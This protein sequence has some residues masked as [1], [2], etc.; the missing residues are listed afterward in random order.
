MKFPLLLPIIFLLLILSSL[1]SQ[2]KWRQLTDADGLSGNKISCIYQ[3]K[4]NDI[5][6]GTDKGINRYN[7]IFQGSPLDGSVNSILELPTGQVIA[8]EVITPQWSWMGDPWVSIKLYDGL[9]WDRPDFFRSL[10]PQNDIFKSRIPEFAV[11]SGGKLWMASRDGLISFDG[12]KWQFEDSDVRDLLWLV[13]TPDG[14]LWSQSWDSIVSFDGQKWTL[15]FGA[16]NSLLDNAIVNTALATLNGMI[17]LGTDQGLFQYD[18]VL[19]S[20]TDLKLGPVNVKLIYESTDHILW[21]GTNQGLFKFGDG[22]WQESITD[23]TINTIQHTNEGQLWVGT[24]NGLYHFDHGE[25][26][27]ELNVPVSCFTQL[28]DGTLLVGGNDGLRVQPPTPGTVVMQTELSGEFVSGLFLASDGK[29]WCRSTAGILSYDGLK[30]TKHAGPDTFDSRFGSVRQ[31]TALSYIYEDRNST[32][33]F[34]GG[35]NSQILSFRDGIVKT[36]TAGGW[37]GRII[38]T[39]QGHL[40][41]TGQSGSPYI[42][43]GNDADEWKDIPGYGRGNPANRF[44]EG[45]QDNRT[46]AVFQDDDGSIWIGG[47]Q[48]IWRFHN[49]QWFEYRDIESK[50]LLGGGKFI[51]GPDGIFRVATWTAIYRLNSDEKW[52]VEWESKPGGYMRHIHLTDD[53]QL[54]AIV[55]NGGLLINKGIRG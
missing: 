3:A 38:E 53:G 42:Y 9:E 20:I 22:R 37:T 43:D 48:G 5:W 28:A 24:S 2:E 10:G 39:K 33:W 18:P 40:I 21:V 27:P 46:S 49:Q 16:D 34:N 32:I 36:H 23:Q 41:A 17:L 26:I 54:I 7:G 8:Y 12:Q 52:V 25:W 31:D 35:N 47:V 45:S 30:W 13:R 15:E 51:R 19:N 55:R 29:L 6:I 14:R 50:P 11:V 44:W 4:N 1:H